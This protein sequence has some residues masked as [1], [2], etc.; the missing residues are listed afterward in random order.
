MSDN[1]SFRHRYRFPP[2]QR[3][4]SCTW[5]KRYRKCQSCFSRTSQAHVSLFPSLYFF[6]RKCR[7][8]SCTQRFYK[9]VSQML[10]NRS[11]L[12]AWRLFIVSIT[13]KLSDAQPFP[14]RW[15]FS[16]C[17]V[18]ASGIPQGRSSALARK[19]FQKNGVRLLQF[20]FS[21]SKDEIF[22]GYPLPPM[23]SSCAVFG[24]VKSPHCEGCFEV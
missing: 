15:D 14:R 5:W 12:V 2:R 9:A 6:W 21:K 23:P 7:M 11:A 4:A 10:F 19:I 18:S 20:H 8:A 3:C 1:P 16:A 13:F 17:K 22:F 24:S